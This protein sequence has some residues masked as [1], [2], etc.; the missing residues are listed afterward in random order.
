MVIPPCLSSFF[1][2]HRFF[3]LGTFA[4]KPIHQLL[5]KYI[6]IS[7]LKDDRFDPISISEISSLKVCVS[8]LKDF[9][10]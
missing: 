9:E 7:A 2:F 4:P 1:G 3:L 8:L 5:P 10:K 6:L